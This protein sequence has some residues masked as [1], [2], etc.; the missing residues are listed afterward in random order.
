MMTLRRVLR[1]LI[2]RRNYGIGFL[3]AGILGLSGNLYLDSLETSI[4]LSLAGKSREL[5]TGDV[6]ISVRRLT[7]E[8]E[9]KRLRDFLEKSAL[10]TSRSI[11]LYSM[12]SSTRG[13][14]LVQLIA[15]ESNFPLVGR[16]T[17]EKN[18]V[19]ESKTPKRGLGEGEVWID[20][21]L[22]ESY[23]L[24]PGDT[25]K[26]GEKM[27]RISDVVLDD[28]SNAW[29][30]FTLAPRIFI[31]LDDL[32]KSG[33]IRKGSTLSDRTYAVLKPG[34]EARTVAK[35]W[36]SSS[37]DSAIRATP[38]E[39]ASEQVGKLSSYLNDYLGLVGL[40]TLFLALIGISFLFQTELRGRLRMIGTLR[41]LGD[42]TRRIGIEIALESLVLGVLSALASIALVFAT[43]PI[44]SRLV[45]RLSGVSVFPVV[46][47]LS[48]L[49]T[50]AL[51][52]FI[53]F[54]TALPFS[55]KVGRLK[56]SALFQDEVHLVLPVSRK[57]PLLFLPL[58][59]LFFVLSI[60][61]S[62][63]FRVGSVFFG[64]A[65]ISVGG[66]FLI[67]KFT[68]ARLEKLVIKNLSLR[69]AVR[70]LARNPWSSVSGFIAMGLGALLLS[71]IPSLQSIIAMEIERPEGSRVPSL[72]FFDIQ[73]EQLGGVKKIVEE[74]GGKLEFI[75]PLV[76]ARLESL[77]GK[78]VTKALEFSER[79]TREQEEEERSR[80]RGFNLSYRETLSDSEV[81]TSGR[82]FLEKFEPGTGRVPEIT[83]E[84]KFA[85]R[86]GVGLGDS[87]GFDIQGILVEAKIVGIRRV[88]W[89]SFQPNFFVLF[90]PGVLNDAPKTFLG[91]VPSS[92][93]SAS[94]KKLQDALVKD[95]PNVS[96]I[97][98]DEMVK[99]LLF[100]FDQMGMAVRV[101]AVLSL[102]TGIF[103]LFSIARRQVELRRRSALLLKAV[104]ASGGRILSIFFWEF[105]ILSTLASV[106]GVAFSLAISK[107]LAWLLF[108]RTDA[109]IEFGSFVAV[110]IVVLISLF[111]VALASYRLLRERPW[112]L[113]HAD[114]ER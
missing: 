9:R 106:L 47:P 11:D 92:L 38:H 21:D 85:D 48:A 67:G 34:I 76:R 1:S 59:V 75:S 74:N 53:G 18:G 72:F 39:E 64:L 81:I 60:Y 49:L 96:I 46:A 26:I 10:E 52:A 40:T 56:P 55:S 41:A 28:T 63:S 112:K 100:M 14:R 73:E 82:N 80:N 103:V 27:F 5:L 104:G 20:P 22:R 16:I 32:W 3:L 4:R 25:A 111:A 43:L 33:L 101:T 86:L 89:S 31:S 61:H 7:S 93:D 37:E 2:R 35:A 24:R 50:L 66:L 51:G 110:G 99:K 15:I 97:Q 65:V 71:L 68:F 17:L 98:V 29:R 23:G 62:H 95:F 79:S 88:R 105:G 8:M 19:I 70:S 83:L 12:V 107:L 78:P 102:I 94:R 13:S 6:S 54:F 30:G 84:D 109:R 113:L 57:D 114:G 91:G 87:I 45:S 108:N 36:N 69:L 44:A 77:K 90:Q 58:A 42:S